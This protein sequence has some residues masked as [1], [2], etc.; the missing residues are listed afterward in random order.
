MLRAIFALGAALALGFPAFGSDNLGA[1]ELAAE[2]QLATDGKYSEAIQSAR[3]SMENFRA[4][5][6]GTVNGAVP[7][8]Y[9]DI[10]RW[11]FKLH[12]TD[13]A[14]EDAGRGLKFASEQFGDRS[15]E[16]AYFKRDVAFLQYV[17]GQCASALRQYESAYELSTGQSDVT[18][19]ADIAS[20]LGELYR[21]MGRPDR[22]TVIWSGTL[23]QPGLDA[24]ETVRLRLDR[25][26][27]ALDSYQ[28]DV[29][30]ADISAAE[31]ISK[32]KGLFDDTA[33][34]LITARMSSASG[35][36]AKSRQI[37]LSAT[38]GKT[39][40]DEP[41]RGLFAELAAVEGL[42]GHYAHSEQ[43]YRQLA[44]SYVGYDETSLPIAL[45]KYGLA[46]VYRMLGDASQSE[47]F[48]NQA[49][50]SLNSCTNGHDM[51]TA[52]ALIERSRLSLD[53]GRMQQ[54]L[55]DAQMAKEIVGSLPGDWTVLSAYA[56]SASSQALFRLGRLEESRNTMLDALKII[57]SVRGPQAE[58]LAPGYVHL[59]E[60]ALAQND[61]AQVRRWSEKALNIRE[62]TEAE[63]VW[64]SGT[65]LSLLASVDLQDR[66]NVQYLSDLSRFVKVV[67]QYVDS[68][69]GVSDLVQGE[70]KRARPL[71]DRV[72][73]PLAKADPD[74]QAR[75]LS[76]INQLLQL[77][78][79]S[80]AGSDVRISTES[81]ATSSAAVS[82][83]VRDRLTLA[84][85]LHAQAAQLRDMLRVD[86]QDKGALANALTQQ[87]A[88]DQ[89]RIDEIDAMLRTQAPAIAEILRPAVVDQTELARLLKPHEA[90]YL[91]FVSA[92]Q[93]H[94]LLILPDRSIYR[95]A[96]IGAATIRRDVSRLRRALDLGTP[97]DNRLPF[98][99]ESALE[100]YRASLGQF[101]DQL[102][103][104]QELIVVPDD[105][106]QNI[107]WSVLR[108]DDGSAGRTEDPRAGRFLAETFSITVVPTA[109]A[110]KLLR[111]KVRSATASRPF[112]GFGDPVLGDSMTSGRW[113][114]GADDDSIRG[115]DARALKQLPPLPQTAVE[116]EDIAKILGAGPDSVVL[117]EAATKA[118]VRSA[119]LSKYRVISFATHGLL[120][121]DFRGLSE[122]ALVMSAGKGL[123]GIANDPLLRASEI[124][125]LNLNAEIVLLS[126]CNSGRADGLGGAYGLSGLSRAFIAAG[127]RS[128]L[129]S[130]WS[131]SS[132]ATVRLLSK[133][134]SL[135]KS[136]DKLTKS[137]AL[138]QAMLWM[139]QGGA[140]ELFKSP[141][142]WAPFILIGD[143]QPL[144][145]TS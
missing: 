99:N 123:D 134:I 139:M 103:N 98:D 129:V 58:D 62:H 30:R 95:V 39:V 128:L 93:V 16:L 31:E 76:D 4:R 63:S 107:P 43:I 17:K 69:N 21:A 111:A 142:Y 97:F 11:E 124:A 64:G 52:H 92:N 130:H 100:L 104:V 37:L 40:Q 36:L 121:G 145:A 96:P 119:D 25:A 14:L 10:A 49:I 86:T 80:Q 23:A 138:R 42:L 84:E 82:Q 38:Q 33:H 83:L 12:A 13:R 79:L 105:A 47:V 66:G 88:V 68:S 27:N 56:S 46:V 24:R 53:L 102:N 20:S 91:Q 132:D 127:A 137:E 61:V 118:A 60:I 90:M 15:P 32:A 48:F 74:L 116:L 131:V 120:A 85:K 81:M 28:L 110:L 9:D 106:Y 135:M 101:A 94:G 67:R 44:A 34:I 143:N 77:S 7:Y 41:V 126:A 125:Q 115:A 141:S 122:P 59:A 70:L 136:N 35:N 55:T 8:L 89:S 29:A 109:G 140:G 3:A 72:L 65:A 45:T 75:A 51:R 5:D 117:K 50:S 1:T 54:A 22:S 113:A 6:A 114:G 87:M 71:F 108:L 26:N 78:Q 57:E 2:R 144:R 112:I 19:H 18:M 73:D 133:V